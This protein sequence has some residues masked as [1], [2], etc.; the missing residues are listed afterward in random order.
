MA[1][2]ENTCPSFSSSCF[3][4]GQSSKRWI[5]ARVYLALMR[6]SPTSTVPTPSLA[7][8]L[9]SS[10]PLIPACRE[11]RR[12]GLY[13][14]AGSSYPCQHCNDY[15]RH[16]LGI[17]L[18]RNARFVRGMQRHHAMRER[19][20]YTED[21]WWWELATMKRTVSRRPINAALRCAFHLVRLP[22]CLSRMGTHV[23]NCGTGRPE[24]RMLQAIL[25]QAV[26]GAARRIIRFSSFAGTTQLI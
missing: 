17:K 9:M 14:Q 18:K 7:Y 6:A 24:D 13:Q 26:L 20:G 4:N 16:R 25:T 23:A 1:R 12:P 21:V 2:N 3:G 11:R 8:P 10:G 19:A 22:S 15:S 5:N